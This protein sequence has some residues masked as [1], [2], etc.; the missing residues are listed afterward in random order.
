VGQ[1]LGLNYRGYN[2]KDLAEKCQCFEEV[3]YLL[4]YGELP[5]KSELEEYI[6]YLASMRSLPKAL[7]TIIETIP[8]STHPMDFIRT[9]CSAL[10]TMEPEVQ[11]DPK[12]A[13]RVGNRLIASFGPMLLY[14]H[15]FHAHGIRI[16]TNTKPTDTIARNFVKLLDND[17]TEP[18]EL[19]VRTLE[20]SLILYAEHE[21]TASTFVARVTASTLADMYSAI[22]AGI[23]ALKGPLHGGA[24]EAA[25]NLI[26]R[27]SSA[28]E[29]EKGVLD[30]LRKKQL[31]FGFGHRVY[32]HGDPRSPIIKEWSKKLSQTEYGNP[33]LF[34][35]SE[36]IEQV[37]FRE[38]KMF[39]NL[40]FYSASAYHQCGIPTKFFTPLFVI[41]RTTG[42]V[43][44][45]VEQRQNN[46]LIRPSSIYVG[47]MPKQFVP[48]NERT[49]TKSSKL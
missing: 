40:D 7:L 3:A 4:Y 39:P 13:L 41:S 32:K 12:D 14:W 46:K 36:R 2:I 9:C 29:A 48:M 17:G 49:P 22:T 27:F 45:V 30:M 25:M 6:R 38:K 37:M 34:A 18:D 8:H 33:K 44:H 47:P 1:G 15:H 16:D 23:A 21:F 28:D 43:A 42:W 26:S 11:E 10:G 20:V 19:R 31:V 24:N 5:T 35:I